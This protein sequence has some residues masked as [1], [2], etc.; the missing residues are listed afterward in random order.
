LKKLADVILGGQ[1]GY[2]GGVEAFLGFASA[3]LLYKLSFAD[4]LNEE[5]GEGYQR[6]R[7]V[8]HSL[9]F[10]RYITQPYSSTI[11]L[12][13]N[14]RKETSEYWRIKRL[15]EGRALLYLRDGVRSLA[16]VD[17]QHR[18]GE[19]A[20]IDIPLAFMTYIGLDL[21]SEM[22]LFNVINS[23]ARGLSSSLTDYH[24]SNLLNDLAAE[25]PHLYIARKLNEDPDSPWYRMILYGGETNSGLK[26][27]TSLRMMQKSIQ[28]FLRQSQPFLQNGIEDCLLLIKSFWKAVKVV[29]P[30][31]WAHPRQ[32]LLTKGVGL[33]SLMF[34]LVDLVRTRERKDSWD[35]FF[36]EKLSLLRGKVDWTSKGTF[37]NAGGQKGALQAYYLLKKVIGV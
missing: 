33:Y 32:S 11:T 35:V 20:N 28:R 2:C 18:L 24:E 21:R 23:R 14:L 12:T 3:R 29:F 25:A 19:L 8:A 22:A 36:I 37:S 6:P 16:Q 7:S 31:Q 17:C 34:L 10:K 26:R 27:R 5:T 15:S 30:D 9:S 4:V 1:I 13:F